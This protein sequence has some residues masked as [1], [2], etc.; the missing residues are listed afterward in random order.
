[1]STTETTWPV[2]QTAATGGRPPRRLLLGMMVAV[3]CSGGV[4]GSG[5]SLMLINRRIE[6]SAKRH[7][8]VIVG[9]QVASELEEKLSLSEEQVSQVD[10]IMK[11]H[12]ASMDRLRREVFF[13]K[14]RESFTQMNEA[15]A[16]VLNDE[17]R[18]QWTAWLEERR[19]RVCP[20]GEHGRHGRGHFH[21]P[22]SEGGDSRVRRGR[23][24]GESTPVESGANSHS[25]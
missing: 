5:A 13:P 18:V 1:M 9:H 21:K 16:A 12:L 4:I 3:F 23:Q 25:D 6:D 20:P 10:R 22:S 14:I 24:D 7:D 17:Q 2:P 15:V 11:E 19:Q 8:P